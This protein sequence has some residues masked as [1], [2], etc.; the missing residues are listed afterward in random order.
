MP[1]SSQ[2]V[3]SWDRYAFVNNNPV[4]YNDPSGHDVGCG[5]RDASAC[6]SRKTFLIATGKDDKISGYKGE[7]MKPYYE[8]AVEKGYQVYYYD[9]D[10]KKYN[11]SRQ[12]YDM[13]DDMAKRINNNFEDE[14]YMFG[15]SA[16]ADATILAVAMTEYSDSVRGVALLDP[17]I[18][19]TVPGQAS[20]SIQKQADQIAAN[21]IP[22]FLADTPNDN[23]IASI[24]GV[25]RQQYDYTHQDLATAVD[26]FMLAIQ[27]LMR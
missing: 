18:T 8:Y 21:G 19:A 10:N 3:Q 14:F 6:A 12:K 13:A 16:G 27:T 1:V 7:T 9:P 2:G 26:V 17:T 11:E 24:P 25:V 5:G 4:R 20:N 15:Y 23:V 22:V